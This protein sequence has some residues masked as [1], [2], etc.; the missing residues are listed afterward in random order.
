MKTKTID[1]HPMV[2]IEK[3]VAQINNS[4]YDLVMVAAQRTREMRRKSARSDNR[5]V[6]LNDAL[7][8]AQAGMIDT[9]AYLAKVR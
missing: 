3:C 2:D 7:L 9:N 6:F 5:P 1:R 4:R 8:E